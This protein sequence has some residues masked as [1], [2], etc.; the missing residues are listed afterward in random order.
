[1]ATSCGAALFCNCRTCMHMGCLKRLPAAAV[2]YMA[3]TVG[4]DDICIIGGGIA[5]VSCVQSLLQLHPSSTSQIHVITTTDTHVRCHHHLSDI[6]LTPTFF[7]SR[8]ARN[9]LHAAPPS[10][11]L[12]PCCC[13]P[14][15]PAFACIWRRRASCARRTRLSICPTGLI[16]NTVGC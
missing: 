5:A 3:H 6:S 10:S 15:P 2:I 12:P 1:M 4:N 16:F 14:S 11:I 13:R 9:A 7:S 8:R